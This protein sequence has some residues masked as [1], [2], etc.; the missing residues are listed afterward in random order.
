M[1]WEGTYL[2][3]ID[4]DYHHGFRGNLLNCVEVALSI[5]I[6]H[7]AIHPPARAGPAHAAVLQLV[8]ARGA[9][10]THEALLVVLTGRALGG[11]IQRR[12]GFARAHVAVETGDTE[13]GAA[14]GLLPSTL[15]G[16]G[17]GD[18]ALGARVGLE[19]GVGNVVVACAGGDHVAGLFVAVLVGGVVRG[20]PVWVARRG[21]LVRE[22]R[23]AVFGVGGGLVA[24]IAEQLVELVLGRR[25]AWGKRTKG[26]GWTLRLWDLGK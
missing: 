2:R 26:I 3:V 7:P 10:F 17:V 20:V 5:D 13:Q 25:H 4:A 12:V 8:H 21:L 16:L 11:R 6:L 19:D 14:E 18:D 23:L 24:V 22:N 9:P 1:I 15:E